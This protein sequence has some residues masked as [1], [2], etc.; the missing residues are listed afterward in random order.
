MPDYDYIKV[1]TSGEPRF[2]RSHSFSHHHRPR[3]FRPRC[4]DNCACVSLEDWNSLVERERNTRSAN[5]TLTRENQTLKTD[6]RATIKEN[7]RLQGINRDQHD[8]IE[9]LKA[10]HLREEDNVGKFRRRMAALK[11]EIDSKDVALHE[12]KKDKE[13]ADIRVRELSQT[14]TDQSTEVTQ[15]KDEIS[16]LRRIHNKD[17]YDL[18]VRTEEVREAWSLVR[19]LQRQLRKCRDP[20]SFRRRWDFA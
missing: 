16:L 8:E 5:E 4:P 12:L 17:Q 10:H 14:V 19:D 6:I 3:H 9:S 2:A 13:I 1:S 20:F 11:A 18:G 15:L 7:R